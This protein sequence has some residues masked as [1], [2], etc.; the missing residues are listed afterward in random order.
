MTILCITA[1]KL[2]GIRACTIRDHH[3]ESCGRGECTGCAPRSADRGFLC[4]RCY[5]RVEYALA[6]WHRFARALEGVERA[7]TV[8]NA[9]ITGTMNGHI[10]LP[11]T[12]LA[13]DECRRLL[14]S[15]PDGPR[16]LEVWVSSPEGAR[17]AI[18]FAHAADRAYRTHEIEER[19]APLRRVRCP[20]CERLT[21]VRRPPQFEREPV[22][23][24][25]SNR[26]CGREIREGRERAH[27][28]QK[29]PD[30]EWQAVEADAVAVIER[31]ERKER[32]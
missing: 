3:L 29:T 18:M 25:C 27:L 7:V 1:E 16:G 26:A 19:E 13:L 21:L 2:P 17:D 28:Y 12:L 15:L 4:Q 22:V 32:A 20:S 6:G 23:V 10:P 11:G 30:G 8:D 9:G 14:A 31:I 24:R 5:E